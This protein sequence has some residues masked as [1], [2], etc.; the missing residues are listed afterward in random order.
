MRLRLKASIL[1]T[2]AIL[3]CAGSSQSQA[4]RVVDSGCTCAVISNSSKVP[5]TVVSGGILNT[6]AVALPRPVFAKGLKRHSSVSVQ[7]IVAEDGSVSKASGVSGAD[8]AKPAAEAAALMARFRPT[9]LN[10]HQVKVSGLI[11]YR[12]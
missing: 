9:L 6:K 3:A 5:P 4:V 12:Y 10:G 2:T 11:F 7:V 1:V 8:Q